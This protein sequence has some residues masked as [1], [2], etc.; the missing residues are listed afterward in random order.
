[1]DL[2]LEGSANANA[3]A[4]FLVPEAVQKQALTMK[5]NRKSPCIYRGESSK[6]LT[7]LIKGDEVVGTKETIE[8]TFYNPKKKCNRFKTDHHHQRWW[9]QYGGPCH[10][11][12]GYTTPKEYSGMTLRWA[13]GWWEHAEHQL[14][15]L[16]DRR[17]LSEQLWL[18]QQWIAILPRRTTPVW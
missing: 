13:D 17:W 15:D 7:I 18:G 3:V 12:N 16:W 4:N 10:T 9:R 2:K 6:T 8:I 1:M 11:K 5:S 14:V